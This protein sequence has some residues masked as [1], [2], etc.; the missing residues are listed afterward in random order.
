MTLLEEIDRAAG[1]LLDAMNEVLSS[2]I[3]SE[4]VSTIACRQCSGTGC[5]DCRFTGIADDDVDEFSL[6]FP[7]SVVSSFSP[8]IRSAA[9]G[10]SNRTSNRRGKNDFHS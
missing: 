5:P 8:L 10:A 6:S 9:L 7:L 3:T 2:D 4:V 1:N